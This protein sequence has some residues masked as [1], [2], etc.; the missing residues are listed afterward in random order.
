MPTLEDV[1]AGGVRVCA[2]IDGLRGSDAKG[3]VVVGLEEVGRGGIEPEDFRPN[4]PGL[5]VGSPKGVF[6]IFPS[7]KDL[8]SVS[9][10]VRM[11]S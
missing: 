9:A 2:A 8:I 10:F 4:N 7:R 5:E 3:G 1:G 6:A 11:G